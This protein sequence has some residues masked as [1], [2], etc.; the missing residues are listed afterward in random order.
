[1][2]ATG[3]KTFDLRAAGI[4]GVLAGVGL[5][6]EFIFFGATGMGAT[7]LDEASTAIPFL[8]EQGAT[9]RMAVL[10]GAA[11]NLLVV[12]L[13]WGIAQRIRGLAPTL[14]AATLLF[15]VVAVMADGLIALS[16]WRAPAFVSLAAGDPAVVNP[17]WQAYQGIVSAARDVAN[18]FVG[19]ALV[20]AGIAAWWGAMSK[21]LGALAL[22]TGIVALAGP[23]G[24][25][26]AYLI[27]LV[28]AIVF[29]LWAGIDLYRA[30]RSP[31]LAQEGIA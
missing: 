10:V 7:T 25:G 6:G 18:V 27:S 12:L 23:L 21:P 20:A 11:N 15:G 8:R 9:L 28:L 30:G 14:A 4:A 24:F 22:V 16:Y 26:F 17:A 1:M 2:T 13:Y 29:R 31:T 19:S 3:T 5:L